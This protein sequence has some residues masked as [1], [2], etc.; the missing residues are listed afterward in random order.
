MTLNRIHSCALI[1][2]LT[3]SLAPVF[4]ATQAHAADEPASVTSGTGKTKFN[5]LLQAWTVDDTK[6]LL[7]EGDVK[8]HI[9]TY[10]FASQRAVVWLNRIPSSAGMINQIAVYFEKVGDPAKEAGL[11]VG[12]NDLLV[13]AS[14]RGEVLLNV[15]L[16]Q[17]KQPPKD[18]FLTQAQQRMAS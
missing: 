4:H 7:M 18:E 9:G 15:T 12:G 16:L 10:T 8:I 13:T 1:A 5:A 6:R 11:G 14:S 3:L 17:T 2:L